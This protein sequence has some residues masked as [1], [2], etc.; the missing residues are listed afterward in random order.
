M[1]NHLVN[2]TNIDL[3]FLDFAKYNA[4]YGIPADFGEI[5]PT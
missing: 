4:F 3:P 2:P 5:P 1:E